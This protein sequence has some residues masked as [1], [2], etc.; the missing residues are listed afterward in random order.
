MVGRVSD[1]ERPRKKLQMDC[2]AGQAGGLVRCG[3]E[4]WS[5]K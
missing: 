4:D 3:V 5:W 1:L 2:V